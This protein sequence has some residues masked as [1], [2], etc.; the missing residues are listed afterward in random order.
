MTLF[1]RSVCVDK[2]KYQTIEIKKAN[3]RSTEF[4]RG[5]NN[6]K[7][8]IPLQMNRK[9]ELAAVVNRFRIIYNGFYLQ[10]IKWHTIEISNGQFAFKLTRIKRCY[11]LRT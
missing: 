2:Q 10:I 6:D 4:V 9:K 8:K 3:V 11:R 1:N 7:Q 5:P